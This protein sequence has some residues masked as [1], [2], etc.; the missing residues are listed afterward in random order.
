MWIACEDAVPRVGCFGEY[1]SGTGFLTGV[2][3]D[4]FVEDGV[5]E[6]LWVR[7]VVGIR[8]PPKLLDIP[9]LNDGRRVVV[10]I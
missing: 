10:S 5:R 4:G 9:G 7:G 8:T 2:R 3:V 1:K 6:L